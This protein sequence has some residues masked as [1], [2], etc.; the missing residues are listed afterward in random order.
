MNYTYDFKQNLVHT[1]K[2]SVNHSLIDPGTIK[3]RAR[4]WLSMKNV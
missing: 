1:G 3:T 2:S 4:F